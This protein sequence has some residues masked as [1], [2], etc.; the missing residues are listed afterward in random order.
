MDARV[1]PAHD[2]ISTM[3]RIRFDFGTLSLEA[4]LLDTPPRGRSPPRCRSR[5][6][7]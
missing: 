6:R 2:G 5:P 3:A 1:K 4:E 7:C